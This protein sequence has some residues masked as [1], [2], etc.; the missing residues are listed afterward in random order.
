MRL[1]FRL[2]P[3]A[4]K[5]IMDL[6]ERTDSSPKDVILDALALYGLIVKE[7]EKG[8]QAGVMDAD[9]NFRGVTTVTLSALI[10][11]DQYAQQVEESK[12]ASA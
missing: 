2:K 3:G 5:L 7:V 1:N 10:D 12:F 9:G 4:E 11:S 6:V 8:S